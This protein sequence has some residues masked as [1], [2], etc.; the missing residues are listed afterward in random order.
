MNT[1]TYVLIDEI[2]E[3]CPSSAGCKTSKCLYVTYASYLSAWHMPFKLAQVVDLYPLILMK[4]LRYD[5][6]EK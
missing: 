4:V 1:T 5:S 2:T 3:S 6:S